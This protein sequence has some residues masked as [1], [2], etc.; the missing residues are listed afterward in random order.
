MTPSPTRSVNCYINTIINITD[1]GWLKYT[2]CDGSV[3]YEY[4]YTAS[5]PLTF[6][7]CVQQGSILPGFPYADLAAFTI[8]SLGTPC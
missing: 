2:T 6:G 5:S 4:V 7:V 1:N 3:N 8:T